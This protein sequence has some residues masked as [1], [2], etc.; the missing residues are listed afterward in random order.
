MNKYRGILAA[1][2]AVSALTMAVPAAHG[3]EA[4]PPAKEH[5]HGHGGTRQDLG[6]TEAAGLKLTATQLGKLEPGSEAIFE[7][8]VP[9]DA[10]PP[11][12]VRIWVGIASA[13]G[14]AKAKAEFD[15]E[16][17]EAHVEVPKPL[18]PTARLW[19]EIQPESGSRSKTSFELKK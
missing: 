18:P 11:K 17:Y 14:S 10:K 2:L 6:T 12:A 9:K 15:G 8:G 5:G 3:A 13:E 19:V 4:T 1:W 16:D 7:I